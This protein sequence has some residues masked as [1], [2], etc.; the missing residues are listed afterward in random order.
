M[1]TKEIIQQKITAVLSPCYFSIVDETWKHA[2]HAGAIKGKGHF[3]VHVVSE[4]F[5]GVSLLNRNRMVFEV[6][7]E[8]MATLIHALTIRAQTPS[9]WEKEKA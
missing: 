1:S 6:L 9:E 2:G 4:K 8:E 3:I 5:E 7:K